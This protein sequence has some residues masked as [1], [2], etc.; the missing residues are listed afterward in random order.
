[1]LI[2]IFLRQL[3]LIY[4][5]FFIPVMSLRPS[6]VQLRQNMGHRILF[7]AVFTNL[8]SK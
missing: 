8:T 4:L 3:I 6:G 2:V 7:V 1:M 5:F